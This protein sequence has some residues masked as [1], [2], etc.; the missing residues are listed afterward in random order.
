[1]GDLE[2]DDQYRHF[3]FAVL[4]A[5]L[6]LA[7]D[8]SVRGRALVRGGLTDAALAP[9]FLS[10]PFGPADIAVYSGLSRVLAAGSLALRWVPG[11]FRPSFAEA[12]I[13]KDNA[14]SLHA[15]VLWRSGA[16]G[17]LPVVAGIRLETD[18]S[19]IGLQS[20]RMQFGL[21]YDLEAGALVFRAFLF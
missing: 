20:N 12:V 11:G 2:A 14:L 3:G 9:L 15:D 19:L 4:T 16:A 18:L 8:L 1:M 6:P 5:E 7:G 17:S 13:M 21:G 10:D